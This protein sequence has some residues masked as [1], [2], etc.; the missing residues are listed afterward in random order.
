MPKRVWRSRTAA[1]ITPFFSTSPLPEVSLVLYPLITRSSPFSSTFSPAAS[2]SGCKASPVPRRPLE[3]RGFRRVSGPGAGNGW[4]ADWLPI[5]TVQRNYDPSPR[6]PSSNGVR[7]GA[8]GSPTRCW[9]PAIQGRD[10][11]PEVLGHLPGRHPAVQELTSRLHFPRG[12][13][14]LAATDTAPPP[15]RSQPGACVRPAA[16]APS[17][18]ATP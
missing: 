6:L 7:P 5:A 13:P 8:D 2:G 4:D 1:F 18:P 17:A 11:N 9:H 15:R 3:T 10:R 12:H 14:P 16:P